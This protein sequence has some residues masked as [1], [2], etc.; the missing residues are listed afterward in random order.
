MSLN[1]VDTKNF[2]LQQE[3]ER[4]LESGSG[5]FGHFILTVSAKTNVWMESVG[6]MVNIQIK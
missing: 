4:V 2:Y 5:E 1:V 6:F 3:R